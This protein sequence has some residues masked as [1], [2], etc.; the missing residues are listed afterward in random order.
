MAGKAINQYSSFTGLA[1]AVNILVQEINQ[2]DPNTFEHKKANLADM[3]KSV[4]SVDD[5]VVGYLYNG[6]F[7]EES[8]HTTALPAVTGRIYI[9]L[10]GSGELY[11]YTGTAYTAVTDN[12]LRS[13]LTGGTVTV[14]KANKDGDGNVIKTTYETKA[15]AS[16]LK[17]ATESNTARIQ[18]LEEKAGDYVPVNYR[19][20]DAVPTGKCKK[21]L[22]N[23]IV[24]KTRAWNQLVHAVTT[25]P[26][27]NNA[28]INSFS[29]GVTTFTASAYRGKLYFSRLYNPLPN[30]ADKV[31]LVA[32]QIKTTTAITNVRMYAYG[33][34]CVKSCVASTS[35]Q[36]VFR[37]VK[38]SSSWGYDLTNQN[39]ISIEDTRSSD[40]DAVQVRKPMCR[41]LSLIAPEFT[42]SGN[43]DADIATLLQKFPDLLKWDAFSDGK[44]ISTEVEGVES[45]S[46]NMVDSDSF[47]DFSSMTKSGDVYS[48]SWAA[49]FSSWTNTNKPSKGKFKENTQ[50]T[51]SWKATCGNASNV[52]WSVK[53]TD[54]TS[55]FLA[56]VNSTSET[57][58]TGTSASGKTIDY[59]VFNYGSGSTFSFRE[60]MVNEGTSAMPYSPYGTLATL[61]ISPASTGHSAGSVADTD[62]LC[63]EVEEGV[64]KRR[65]TTK[66][67]KKLFAS[68]DSWTK[69]A[70]NSFYI[71]L[72][73]KKTGVV[74]LTCNKY[75][76][77]QY[78]LGPSA[79]VDHPNMIGQNSGTNAIYFYS[80]DS[81][82]LTEAQFA[83][84]MAGV[85]IYFELATPTE[86]LSDP[87]IDNLITTE[88]GG[89]IRTKQ[90]QGTEIDNSLD[91]GYLALGA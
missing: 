89:T 61:S 67:G 82:S 77:Y 24:H 58:A 57:Y 44:T 41:D 40:W 1:S 30:V 13:A 5:V 12:A 73:D 59:I 18:N 10:G 72:V 43:D 65:K 87:I 86:T 42:P 31:V 4:A 3:I 21:A 32:V 52:G 81:A 85:E 7:Y 63:V 76:A 79:I 38:T 11:R 84:Y 88:G 25:S 29:D 14:D 34:Y 74:G 9:D 56:S 19:G 36:T 8:A 2:S 53:Y 75:I 15:D 17:D 91:V 48:C 37:I 78:S 49:G 28:T 60:L 83:E 71:S 51:I 20:T 22:V 27:T 80:A 68:T 47:L 70:Q 23:T 26:Q 46:A 33:G 62:E 90:T 35:W 66:V 64:F 54:G 50:Y 45:K 39:E 16:L 6:T 55:S 69:T